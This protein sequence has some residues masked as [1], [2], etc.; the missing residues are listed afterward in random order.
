MA[1]EEM[2][3]IKPLHGDEGSISDIRAL[4][5]FS[6]RMWF[7]FAKQDNW[8]GKEREAIVKII[9]A[10]EKVPNGAEARIVHDQEGVPHSFSISECIIK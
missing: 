6:D 4:D 9:Q 5:E 7:Y 3:R 1:H 10:A 2:K 8:V